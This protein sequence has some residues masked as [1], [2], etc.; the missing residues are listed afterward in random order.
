MDHP[1]KVRSMKETNRRG[2]AF[3]LIE[4][5][6]VIAI[7]AI[8]AG[9]LWPA[10]A[11]AKEK[12]R[13]IRCNSNLH[14]HALGFAMYADDHRDLYPAYEE[15]ATSGG[16]TGRMTLA[17]GR[18]PPERRPLNAYVPG[19]EA[20]HCPSDKGDSLW[21]TIFTA[22]FKSAFPSGRQSS[23]FEAYGNSYLVPWAVETLRIQH[24]TGNSKEPKGTPAATPMKGSEIAKSP[25]NKLV[26]GDWPSWADRDKND[27]WSQWHNYKGQYRFNML[28]GD[29]HTQFFQFPQEAYKWNY[30]GP[31][32][33]PSFTWW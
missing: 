3:T 22:E 33:D 26:S 23:C 5:L 18:V 24:V 27:K 6:V 31:K 30:T 11:R 29:G 20:W 8:L 9:M 28:F 21:K 10:L 12:G 17:G 25:S 13:T 19:A 7:I 2:L 15:W 14:Q 32:P 4:L 16:T 1:K